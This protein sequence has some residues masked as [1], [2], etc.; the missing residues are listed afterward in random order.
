MEIIVIATTLL[1]SAFFSGMEIAFVSANKLH[2]SLEK[3]QD[4]FKSQLLK[5]IT[6]NPSHFIATMLVGNN[7][8]LVLY[9]FFMGD[10]LL[11]KTNLDVWFQNEWSLLTVQ[12]IITTVIILITAEFLPKVFFQIYANEC[13]KW[14]SLPAYLF[15]L[16]LY[17][18]TR[19]TIKLSD[20]LLYN[21]LR[22]PRNHH[23]ELF[24]KV[25]LGDYINEQMSESD[26]NENMDSEIQIFKKAL[27]FSKIKAREI[28]TPRTEIIAVE[29]LENID[30]LKDEFVNSGFSKILI[31]DQAIDNILGYVHSFDLFKK[32]KT[33][34][35]IMK[36]VEFFPETMYVNDIMNVLTKKRISVGII[37]DEYG[38]T[39]GMVTIEDIVEEL[40]GEI[41]DEHDEE[42]IPLVEE[43]IESQT[44]LFSARQEVSYLNETYQ[45]GIPESEHYSTL[46]GY[47]V[48]H[49]SQ[50][51][52][53]DKVLIFDN[54]KVDILE[55]S[56]TKIELVKLEILN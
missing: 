29:L 12:T 14:F 25:E 50:I 8:A 9:G 19:L 22:S 20:F 7:L 35:T 40:F 38:G 28:M 11:Q 23:S 49:T 39:S 56:N 52:E 53:K 2:I 45:L 43:L 16:I 6:Q 10:F 24:T 33:I 37:I 5:K 46:G 55:V 17:L 41:E 3:L 54:F 32:P 1:L 30:L 31:Y 4:N 36:P 34:K 47:I 42:E 44:Y 18:P 13:I 15:F 48:S 51:P 21:I 26:D 27:D